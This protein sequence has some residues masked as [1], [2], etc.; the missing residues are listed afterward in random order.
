M[1]NSR[2]ASTEGEGVAPEKG[3]GPKPKVGEAREPEVGR[4]PEIGRVTR[5]KSPE[6]Y[7]SK[8]MKV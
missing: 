6:V 2:G 5:R 1:G 4:E 8:S 3:D 7:I